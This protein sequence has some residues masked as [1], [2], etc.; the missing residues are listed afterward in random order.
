[1]NVFLH[2]KLFALFALFY[3]TAFFAQEVDVFLNSEGNFSATVTS[4]SFNRLYDNDERTEFN[5]NGLP[6]EIIYSSNKTF[7][8]KR[9]LLTSTSQPSAKDPK[10]AELYGSHDG[11]NWVMLRNMTA[12]SI[13][14][15]ERK[16]TISITVSSTQPYAYFKFKIKSVTDGGTNC[17]ISEW[18]LFGEEKQLPALP[19]DLKASAI[20]YD[21]VKLVWR[22]RSDDEDNFELQRSNNGKDYVT[23]ATL[24]ANTNQFVDSLVNSNSTYFYRIS[25]VKDRYKSAYCVSNN[26]VT[27]AFPEMT[28]LTKGRLFTY[29]DQYNTSPAGEDISCAFDGDS[30]TKFLARSSTVW[31]RVSFNSSFEV[32]QYSI[33]SANDSPGRDPKNW[34]LEG[35]DNGTS[36]TALDTRTNQSFNSRFQKRY[37]NVSNPGSY[38]YYRLNVNAN[39]GDG[40][41][42]QLADW[43][44]YADV[45]VGDD[46]IIPNKPANFK[47]ENR[48]YH[49]VKL[50]WSD[51]ANE[52]SYRI[53]RSDDGGATFNYTYEIPA[54]NTETYPYSLKPE[55][56][57]VFKLYA[58]N[59][60]S[61]SEPS[62]VSVT[63][64]EKDFKDKFENYKLWIL[65]QPAN[66]NKVKEIGNTA[67]YVLEGYGKDDINDLYYDFYAANW[68]YVFECY[69]DELSDSCLH[70]LLIPMEEGGGLAS[71]YDYRSS[72]SFYRNMVY[73]KANKSWFKNRSE[74]GYI[75]DVM[76][77]ELCHI[78]EGVGGG[79]NGSMFYPIWG[80]SKWAEILQYDVFTALG[81]S[82]AA[83]W[84]SS[85]TVGTNPGGGADYPDSERTSYWYRD[86]LY[87]TYNLYGKTAM[88]KKF[89]K[90]Q[91]QYYKMKNGSFQGNS[92]NPGGRGNLGELIHFWSAAAGVD[93]KPFA[94]KAFGWND[95]FEYWLQQAKIDYPEL[96][97]DETPIDNSDT[98]I[99]QN[100][101]VLSSNY[102]I[103]KIENFIDNNYTTYF[104]T[105]KVNDKPVLDL[106]YKSAEFAKINQYT[107]TFNNNAA[108][109]S[110][111]LLGS[112]DGVEWKVLDIQDNPVL[113]AGKVSVTVSPESAYKFF[114]FECIFPA[115]GSV[116]FAE[117]EI[118]GVQHPGAPHNLE[119]KRIN[120]ETVSL[121]WSGNINE[122]E[123]YEIERSSDGNNF[124][125]IAE[126]S[127]Y[128]ISFIDEN[129]VPG[130]YSYRV[131]A[132]NKNVNKE[133]VRSNV[134]SIDTNINGLK[135]TNNVYS[136]NYIVNNLSTFP[137]N[138]VEVYNLM[139]QRLINETYGSDDLLLY[140]KN[141]L[142]Q[143]VYVIK[144]QVGTDNPIVVSSKLIMK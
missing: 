42:T 127:T 116:R 49:H 15:T 106:V 75:Y 16:Q 30:S 6:N 55:T 130:L 114:K 20:N 50:S 133:N 112:S 104:L 92:A 120:E 143:G 61:L 43:L 5:F 80:D 9:I 137:V 13:N 124:S 46:V 100:G 33:T 66:F 118:F 135:N 132:I 19:S 76:A 88:L 134:A 44:L 77:H 144:I 38:K 31:L 142:S 51:V 126:I 93:V 58:V 40:S 82:R 54:N 122:I 39:N 110:W 7:A 131:V 52:T 123:K 119:A 25:S 2:R 90:L 22:D 78:V 98:N 36:W 60:N 108:P 101:G 11:K 37:F 129:L 103:G 115:S 8:I 87:P 45:A 141:K 107:L 57:Y 32:E 121:E 111:K 84:H 102:S 27:P 18:R 24:P 23:L 53:E 136:F 14:F 73:I 48:A 4:T 117:I 105:T 47:L 70:V 83:S 89:W 21:K 72:S 17:Y 85:Y 41:M 109:A 71:I 62:V 139:G 63:T 56:D 26:V 138:T 96:I 81:S 95:Q 125:K 28:L 65:D 128:D 3:S 35:S 97:Y 91:G 64:G 29:Q 12:G 1:M 69:G 59:G 94:I 74:S 113:S 10:E 99:C 140:L 67:F 34:R 79:Y 86:F 68:K